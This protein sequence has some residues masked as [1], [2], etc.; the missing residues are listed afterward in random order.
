MS[1][2]LHLLD[3]VFF[4]MVAAFLVFRLRAVLGKRTGAERPPP[5]VE[6][7]QIADNVIDISNV[8]K[9]GLRPDTAF[10]DI[11][12]GAIAAADRSFSPEIFLE[13]ARAAFTMIVAAFAE[14]DTRMLRPLLSDEVYRNFAG[15]IESRNRAGE[16]L[17]T[18][19]QG[20]AATVAGAGLDGTVAYVSVRFVSRQINIRRDASDHIIE[21]DPEQAVEVIDEWTFRRDTRSPDPNWQL[22]ATRSPEA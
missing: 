2:S 17:D 4:A 14:G 3:I 5:P 15:A 20:V 16:R 21:G 22:V 8:R 10:G 11:G 12:L 7:R 13:G 18:Q 1:D 6:A 9:P 19:L